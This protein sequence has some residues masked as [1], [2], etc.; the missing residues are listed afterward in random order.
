MISIYSNI[1]SLDAEINLNNT[2]LQVSKNMAHLS[3]GLRIND[4]SDDAAGLGIATLFTAQT[5]SYQQAERN[6]N[7]GIS[8]LQ[9]G[10][11]AL[12]QVQTILTRMRELS[13]QS[14]NGTYDTSDRANI[15]VEVQQL[16]SE[17]DRI[18]A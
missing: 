7:D 15:V 5:D 9:T 6:S 17:I 2:Q 3:S 10:D 8:L 14:A 12:A 4:A 13:V 11:G 18:S 16:Q 1:S